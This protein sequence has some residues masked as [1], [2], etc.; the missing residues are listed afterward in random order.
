MPQQ[1]LRDYKEPIL[2]WDHNLFNLGMH[3]PG[4]YCGFDTFSPTDPLIASLTHAAT[5][6]R[7]KDQINNAKGPFGI[8][9]SPQ[10]IIIMEEDDVTGLTFD[11]N[12]GNTERRF[13]LIVINHNF[14]VIEGGSPATYSVIKGPIGNP[15][16]PLLA[17]VYHQTVIGTVEFAPNVSDLGDVI[18]YKAKCPDSG[19]GEDARLHDVN[20]FSKFNGLAF[21][22]TVYSDGSPTNYSSGGHVASLWNLQEDGNSFRFLPSSNINIDAIRLGNI[23]LR[24]GHR[25]Y[26][27]VNE[28]CLIRESRFFEATTHFANGYRGFKINAGIGNSIFSPSGGGST[29]GIKPSAGEFWELEC[30]F[31]N[32]LWYVSKI[33]NAGSNSVFVRGDMI[34]WYGDTSLNFD[35]QGLG[36]NLKLGWQI[37]NGNNGA[38]DRRGKGTIMATNVPSS[39]QPTRL[40]DADVIGQGG[41]GEDY[42]YGDPYS[43]QGKRKFIITQANLPNFGLNVIDPGHFHNLPH[44]WN[45]SG[46]GHLASGGNVDEG[47]SGVITNTILT[48]ITV[49]LGGM[50]VRLEHIHPVWMTV[51]IM[52][53]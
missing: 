40:N 33:G 52:K 35:S 2:S 53:L 7:Y 47:A 43:I 44:L 36:I 28:K 27:W 51:Y 46:T 22:D 11:T 25:L 14:D 3:N 41:D 15:I 42:T 38:P 5:G 29:L 13:D 39:G 49:F 19:D 45:E 18:Y 48:G 10:G 37:C 9:I 16:K 4:R 8:V 30:I 31:Y 34:E 50:D 23:P 26:L 20:L 21:S 6:I 12:A 17:D 24:N 1:R 32:D